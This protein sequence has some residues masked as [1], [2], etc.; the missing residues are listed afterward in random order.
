MG[1]REINAAV[2]SGFLADC[3]FAI[4][5]HVRKRLG[6]AWEGKVCGYYSTA[7]TPRGVCVESLHHAG[8]VQIYPEHALEM[9]KPGMD[10]PR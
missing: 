9:V 6:Y 7:L 8:S 1:A 10:L 3:G 4:G 2:W 5:D